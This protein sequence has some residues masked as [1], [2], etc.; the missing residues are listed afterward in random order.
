M[1]SPVTLRHSAIFQKALEDFKSDLTP[2]EQEEITYTTLPALKKCIRSIQDQHV[3][4]RDSKNMERL[5]RFLEG[6]E[7]Y[8]K[9]IEVF[10]NA[11]A[12]LCFIW[13]SSSQHITIL[14]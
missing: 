1:A 3:R 13:V 5:R 7:Q 2:E 8:S 6:M 4:S 11:S 9:V 10:T 14:L 12:I